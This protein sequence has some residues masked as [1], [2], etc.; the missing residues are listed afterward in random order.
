MSLASLNAG[1][2]EI[3]RRAMAATFDYFTVDFGSRIGI[4]PEEMRNLL[5]TWPDLDDFDDASPACVAINNS[6]NDLLN[7]EGISESDA[8]AKIGVNRDEMLRVY[9]KWAHARGWDHTGVR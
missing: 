8:L 1:E 3:V 2:R 4:E 9:V 6:L 7:G 5:N